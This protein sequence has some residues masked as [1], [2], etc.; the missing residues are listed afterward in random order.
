MINMK[1][2][3]NRLMA[4]QIDADLGGGV[5]KMRTARTGEGKSSG[6]RVIVFFKFKER[7]FFTYCF[8]KAGRAN[9]DQGELQAFK[10]NA[11]VNFALTD[12]QINERLRNGTLIEVI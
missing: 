11:K 3:V 6:Y 4:G 1:E 12:E 8:A 7:V 9:I 5:Y 10:E 2:I